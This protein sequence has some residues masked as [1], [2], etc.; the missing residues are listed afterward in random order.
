MISPHVCCFFGYSMHSEKNGPSSSIEL[1]DNPQ[2]IKIRTFVNT[3]KIE[4]LCVKGK[5]TNLI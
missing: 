5:S 3:E 1:V 4:G 2:D